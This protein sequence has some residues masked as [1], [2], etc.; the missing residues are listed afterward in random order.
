MIHVDISS[1][2]S[3]TN[4]GTLKTE[5]NNLDIDKLVPVSTDFSKLSNVVKKLKKQY[6]IN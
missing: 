4:L 3:K 5:V 6:L 2:A 1:F